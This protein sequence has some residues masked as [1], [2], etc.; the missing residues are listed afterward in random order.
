M[1]YHEITRISNILKII[2]YVIEFYKYL[3]DYMHDE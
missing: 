1:Q 2:Y 3:W